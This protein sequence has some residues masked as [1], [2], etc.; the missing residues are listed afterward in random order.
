MLEDITLCQASYEQGPAIEALL[1]RCI[2]FYRFRGYFEVGPAEVQS[3]YIGLPEGADYSQKQLTAA[4]AGE[5]A[6]AVLDVILGYPTPCE[7]IVGLIL[8]DPEF[9]SRGIGTLL[10]DSA[11][12][13]ASSRGCTALLSNVDAGDPSER[14]WLNHGFRFADGRG[15]RM[16]LELAPSDP[17]PASA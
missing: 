11:R 5:R 10:L 7:A 1:A 17:S 9:R 8:V 4:F 2:D 13:A 15:D 16:R 14:F 12:R 3:L 6:V